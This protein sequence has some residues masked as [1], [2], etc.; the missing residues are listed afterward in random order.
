[1][2]L[3]FAQAHND[4]SVHTTLYNN[5]DM[6]TDIVGHHFQSDCVNYKKLTANQNESNTNGITLKHEYDF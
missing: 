6:V 1:M 4:D 3:N 5:N 2:V